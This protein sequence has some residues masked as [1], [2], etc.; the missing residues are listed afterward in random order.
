LPGKTSYAPEESPLFLG[1]FPFCGGDRFI[2]SR[3]ADYYK[4]ELAQ[5]TML[6]EHRARD[7]SDLRQRRDRWKSPQNGNL[8]H[9]PPSQ[10]PHNK[11]NLPLSAEKLLKTQGS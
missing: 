10:L 3:F 11:R 4:L 5:K 7:L 8:F 1:G 9:F 2:L 6:I